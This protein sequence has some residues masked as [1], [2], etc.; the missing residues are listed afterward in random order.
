MSMISVDTN[1]L[2]RVFVDD[3]SDSSQIDKA[4]QAVN[5]HVRVY[6]S[7]IV[8]VETV[9]VLNSLYG[10]AKGQ[11]TKVLDHVRDNQ[12]FVVEGEEVFA[13][14]LTLYREANMDFSDALILSNSRQKGYPLLTFDKKFLKL[15]GVVGM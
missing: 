11:I 4:R 8:L 14:A 15:N 2:I 9:W 13:E 12:A 1:I 6:I 7:Q 3:Q 5:K 10:F